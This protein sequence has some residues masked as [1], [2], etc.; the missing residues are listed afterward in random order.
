[1]AKTPPKARSA[2]IHRELRAGSADISR[3]LAERERRESLQTLLPDLVEQFGE[4]AAEDTAWAKRALPG[5]RNK[6][7][8]SQSIAL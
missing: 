5:K 2:S 8:G 7:S 4:P 3:H 1:M 6:R